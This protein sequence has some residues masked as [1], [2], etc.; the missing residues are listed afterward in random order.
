MNNCF[1]TKNK[2][3]LD[4]NFYLLSDSDSGIV[5]VKH[6]PAT[7]TNKDGVETEYIAEEKFYAPN[8]AQ[9]L[10]RFVR[11]KQVIL[12]EVSEMLEVQKQVLSILEDFK[13]KY[14]NWS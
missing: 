8:V 1:K 14:S 9:I 7:R 12:P 13:T 4:D 2:I 5:L 11:E 10:E 3:I 6:Y